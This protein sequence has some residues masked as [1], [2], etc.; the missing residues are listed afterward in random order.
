MN[1][2]NFY[3]GII[4]TYPYGTYILNRS[5]ILIIKSKN[6]PSISLKPLLL[7]EN[8][9][10]LGIIELGL[11]KEINLKQFTHLK[12]YHLISESDR[13]T[14]WDNYDILYAYVINKVKFFKIPLLLGYKTGPQITVRSENI[15]LRKIYIGTS[16]LS[17]A[18][19]KSYSEKLSSLEINYTFYR[20]PTLTFINNL[21]KYNLSYTVKVH[22]LITHYNQLKNIRTKWKKFSDP[23]KILKDRIICFLFQFSPK[24][25]FDEKNFSKLVK[26]ETYLTGKYIFAFEFRDKLWFNDSIRDLFRKN[27]WTLVVSYVINTNNWAGNLSTGFN[28]KLSSDLITTS[29]TIYFRLHGTDGQYTGAY[30]NRMLS[31]I[32]KFIRTKS[33]IE[34]V[35]IYFNNTDNGNAII[36]ANKLRLK[37]NNLNIH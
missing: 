2:I 9:M 1:V 7:I 21:Q 15:W 17:G 25:I 29:N 4:L 19:F 12:K 5:K 8:K 36:D 32:V 23:F 14:W 3:R 37:F 35:L 10:G 28:P 30:S 31:S 13:V 24:F 20:Q 11:P 6:I 34:N 16:G 18:T 33:T 26:L 27:N 22:Q